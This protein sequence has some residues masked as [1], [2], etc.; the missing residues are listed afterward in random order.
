MND[1][2]TIPPMP[3]LDCPSWCERDHEADWRQHVQ[4][5]MDTRGIPMAD[6]TILRNPMPLEEWCTLDYFGP[7][8]HRR[9]LAELHLAERDTI[10]LDLDDDPSAGDP[11]LYLIAEA[12]LSAAEARQL[13]AELVDAANRLDCL[14][15]TT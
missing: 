12:A 8:A 10:T 4:T 5:G 11:S 6:G 3:A 2:S 15:T 1:T 14:N 7:V 13:A 9:R